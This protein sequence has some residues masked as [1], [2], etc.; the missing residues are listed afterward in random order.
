[1]SSPREQR[2][3]IMS[4][5]FVGCCKLSFPF[6]KSELSPEI[7]VDLPMPDLWK[8]YILFSPKGITWILAMPKSYS[9]FNALSD[10]LLETPEHEIPKNTTYISFLSC[11]AWKH[12]GEGAARKSLLFLKRQLLFCCA[13]KGYYQLIFWLF[14]GCFSAQT[15]LSINSGY[16]RVWNY[17]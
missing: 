4:W 6:I 12:F 3:H 16:P 5:Y 11:Q 8:L 10:L 9:G 15:A 7:F 14:G 2:G 13:A 1:M 17:S